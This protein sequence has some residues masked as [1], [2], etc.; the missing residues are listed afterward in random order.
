VSSPPAEPRAGSYREPAVERVA[1]SSSPAFRSRYAQPEGR[2]R[3]LFVG[4]AFAAWIVLSVVLAL[5]VPSFGAAIASAV[6]ALA[7]LVALVMRLLNAPRSSSARSSTSVWIEDDALTIEQGL[8]SSMTVRELPWSSVLAVTFETDPYFDCFVRFDFIVDDRVSSEAVG[9]FTYSDA[10]SLVALAEEAVRARVIAPLAQSVR[11]GTPLS[12]G[13]SVAMPDAF[14]HR[15]ER[16]PWSDIASVAPHGRGLL[17]VRRTVGAS[18]IL[19]PIVVHGPRVRAILREAFGIAGPE[20]AEN[21]R[22]TAVRV[23]L[24]PSD[25]ER[26]APSDEP[27][28]RSSSSQKNSG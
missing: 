28:L 20:S 10:R 23:A 2:S 7:I 18:P 24:D 17:F 9:P 1:P 3:T 14:V 12:I 26:S 19:E 25:D 13:A 5:S 6:L 4:L 22:S 8:A 16:V 27:A 11:A 21:T 15:G